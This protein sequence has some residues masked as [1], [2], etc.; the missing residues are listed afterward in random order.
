M[1]IIHYQRIFLYCG[2]LVFSLFY[3]FNDFFR[4]C[5]KN[6]QW[7]C[8]ICFVVILLFS[9]FLQ[10]GNLCLIFWSWARRVFRPF[11]A[12]F[13][14]P[15]S[16]GISLH[17]YSL[18]RVDVVLINRHGG[19]MLFPSLPEVVESDRFL[20]TLCWFWPFLQPVLMASHS[21]M[22]LSWGRLG[23]RSEGCG[24]KSFLDV[25]VER[26]RPYVFVRWPLQ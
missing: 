13:S 1:C 24:S 11:L 12:F 7:Y 14:C 19:M 20:L 2:L 6:I 16:L 3:V 10:A 9:F 23:P 26:S 4:F 15:A 17:S 8:I 21:S 22:L 18:Y 25:F 5:Y